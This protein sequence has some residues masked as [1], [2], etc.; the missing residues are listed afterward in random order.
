MTT[1]QLSVNAHWRRC[2][3]NSCTV[4]L[5]FSQ[6]EHLK[7]RPASLCTPSW[8]ETSTDKERNVFWTKPYSE[9]ERPWVLLC[10]SKDSAVVKKTDS[11]SLS[12]R[13]CVM[14]LI[15]YLVSTMTTVGEGWCIADRPLTLTTPFPW[16]T[17]P[18]FAPDAALHENPGVKRAKA[19]T[20]KQGSAWCFEVLFT[21]RLPTGG[22]EKKKDA[23][24]LTHSLTHFLKQV[25]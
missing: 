12:T 24:T 16:M 19:T 7:S 14:T 3:Q 11:C 13:C 5:S 8:D 9:R 18:V 25:Q 17:N 4:A 1:Q 10:L 23:L 20:A 15:I 6:S 22:G 21:R 2:M